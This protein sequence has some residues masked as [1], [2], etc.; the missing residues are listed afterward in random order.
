MEI[1]VAEKINPHFDILMEPQRYFT[2]ANAVFE[3]GRASTKSSAI[4]I[5]LVLWF[6]D[7]KNANIVTF[8]KVANTLSGSVYEQIKWAII[9]LGKEDRFKFMKS[10]LRIIDKVT[11]SGFYFFGVDD[12]AKQKSQKIAK[13]YVSAMW[14]EELAEFDSWE[15]VDTVRLT[16]TRQKL[17]D[18]KQVVTLYS[19]NP[20]RNPYDWVNT[21]A[22]ERKTMDSWIVDHSTY[23]DDEMHFLSDQYI[24]E[25]EA[26]KERDPDYYRWQF[27]GESVGLGTNV[28]NMNMFHA[29]DEIPDDDPITQLAYS[30]DSG[31]AQSA[32]T[33]LLFG[34]TAKRK[35]I[36]LDTYYYSPAGKA[37]KL[38]PSELSVN[39]HNFIKGQ[40][41]KPWGRVN[42]VR[43]TIDSAEAA[44]RNQQYHDYRTDLHPVAKQK[45]TV[46]IDNVYSLLASGRFYYLN[47]EA[48]QVFVEQNRN[49]RW[50]EKTINTPEPR[51]IKEDD[52]TADAFQYFVLDN[53]RLLG[54][55]N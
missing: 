28:Y 4:S 24:A 17:P 47:S 33:V 42:V 37:V 45:K 23:L 44:L 11:G 16:Y 7:D 22:E 49:Y 30:V 1:N 25:I 34:M 31:H 9:E 27:L 40:L 26:T 21:W 5:A 10:P 38:A 18:G 41:D 19:Y 32:T 29:L 53:L 15:E 3:G 39:I 2:Y 52:H 46:M 54:L 13:G 50:E 12:P 43:L 48:N 36:L 6:L 55:K 51:V 35:V 20:P 14:F 8:R